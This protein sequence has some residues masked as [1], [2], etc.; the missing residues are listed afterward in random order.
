MKIAGE[1]QE[2]EKKEKGR[3]YPASE[4]IF[5]GRHLRKVFDIPT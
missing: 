3:P 2:G 5:Y 4:H 1:G